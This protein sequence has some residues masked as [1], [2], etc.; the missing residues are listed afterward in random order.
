MAAKK[1]KKPATTKKTAKTA[2]KPAMKAKPRAAGAKPKTNTKTKS[3]PKKGRPSRAPA[4]GKASTSLGSLGHTLV[5]ALTVAI[6]AD[7]EIGTA[8]EKLL[9]R[10]LKAPLFKGLDGPS[11]VEATIRECVETGPDAIYADIASKLTTKEQREAAFSS[12]LAATVSDGKVTASEARMLHAL[13]DAFSLS[14]ARAKSLAGPAAAIF[15]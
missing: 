14:T 4:R 12:C 5:R 9:A 11:I 13:K 8:E 15:R 3:A 10:F 2:K 7:G 1:S 6:V